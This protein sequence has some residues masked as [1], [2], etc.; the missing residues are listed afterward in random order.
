MSEIKDSFIYNFYDYMKAIYIYSHVKTNLK[1]KQRQKIEDVTNII[2]I[3]FTLFFFI[4]YLYKL[5][6]PLLNS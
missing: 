6:L 4:L 1:D 2:L 3:I 5:L